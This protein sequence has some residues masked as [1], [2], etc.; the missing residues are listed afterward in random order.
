[1][2]EIGCVGWKHNCNSPMETFSRLVNP[3]CVDVECTITT[4]ASQVSGLYFRHVHQ[5][6][7]WEIVFYEWYQYLSDIR[8][9]YGKILMLAHNSVNTDENCLKFECARYHLQLPTF[10][11][12][13]D[14]HFLYKS[15]H[16]KT[17]Q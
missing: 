12:F 15:L 2:L 7:L 1:M 3:S 8:G 9:D 16:E 5:Q 14:T 4:K 10:L 11:I 6:E 17:S 13:H